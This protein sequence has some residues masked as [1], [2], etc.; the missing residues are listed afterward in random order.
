[1]EF[2]ALFIWLCL[3]LLVGGLMHYVMVGAL[4]HRLVQ[5]LA[6]PGMVVRK[7]TMSLTA[8]LCGGTVTR[9][10]IYELSS[11]DIDFQADGA[12]SVAKVLVPLAPLFGCAA[13]MVALNAIF[14]NPLNLNY[15][16]P[17][18]ASLD[19]GGLKGFFLG[20]WDLLSRVIRQAARADWG[21]L[22]LYVLFALTFSL[23]LGACA[24]LERVKEAMLGAGLIAV[25][26][27][28]LSSLAV[29]RGP[30][31]IPAQPEWFVGVKTF[32]VGTSAAAFVMMIYGMA[33]ALVTGLCVRAY[34]LIVKSD[35]SGKGKTANLRSSG[36]K[37]R[38]A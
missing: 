34:E 31:D 35:R 1:M 18:L 6:A 22:D 9:V 4:S 29:R 38:A 16:P 32:I 2:M 30:A 8:L 5:L 25:V 3:C 17:A 12:S 10:R 7:F 27:A 33:G 19:S 28:V 23:A 13:L 11:R 20:T 26:L 24:P 37:K 21:S 15:A 14:G 36:N